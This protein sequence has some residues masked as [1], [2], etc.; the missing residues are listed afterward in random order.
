MRWRGY[1]LHSAVSAEFAGRPGFG[2]IV[3][4]LPIDVVIRVIVS[5]LIIKSQYAEMNSLFFTY[6]GGGSMK[7]PVSFHTEVP[8]M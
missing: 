3:R 6:M 7:Q 4:H 8:V 2:K 5:T 1:C